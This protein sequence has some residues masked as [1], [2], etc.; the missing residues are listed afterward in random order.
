MIKRSFFKSITRR[1]ST[2]LL[3]TS[4]MTMASSIALGNNSIVTTNAG[5]HDYYINNSEIKVVGNGGINIVPILDI[6]KNSKPVL[7]SYSIYKD[8]KNEDLQSQIYIPSRVLNSVEG[9]FDNNF[10]P[11]TPGPD[12]KYIQKT[13]ENE[14]NTI[15]Q[16][17]ESV[18]NIPPHNKNNDTSVYN[19]A[20][21]KSIQEVEKAN[22]GVQLSFGRGAA[23][24]SFE[25]TAVNVAA[26]GTYTELLNIDKQL[27]NNQL[28]ANPLNDHDL[29]HIT[30]I[31]GFVDARKD[32]SELENITLYPVN[33]NGNSGLKLNKNQQFIFANEQGKI[34]T[35]DTAR[36]KLLG[37][38]DSTFNFGLKNDDTI[39]FSAIT[40]DDIKYF[41]MVLNRR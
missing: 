18:V 10:F 23:A 4:T 14:K 27:D 38:K 16:Y 8:Q 17:L 29:N 6:I 13:G 9:A 5:T 33:S 40:D 21:Y 31:R 11:Y 15:R 22:I 7:L 2:G 28:V 37:N 1:I 26:P 35:S 39:Y 20:D 24:H 32:K 19:V 34:G 12:G 25:P 36:I 3:I 41:N 30:V